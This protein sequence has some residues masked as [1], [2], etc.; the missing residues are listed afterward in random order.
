MMSLEN[1]GG[2]VSLLAGLPIGL[3][4]VSMFLIIPS[5]LGIIALSGLYGKAIL[6]LFI[7]F[8][9]MLWLGGR[10]VVSDILKMK[11]RWKITWKYSIIINSGIWTVCLLTFVINNWRD[12]AFLLGII[13]VVIL[14]I[15][16]IVGTP[17]TISI[18]V[19]YLINYMIKRVGKVAS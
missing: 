19:H 9:F 10:L 13:P 1:K 16:S 8:P 2:L 4:T 3:F 11:V 17:F 6:G 7:T 15:I 5:G 14:A 18:L 12:S